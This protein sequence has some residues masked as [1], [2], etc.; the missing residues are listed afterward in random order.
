MMGTL[1]LR[2]DL[3]D[4]EKNKWLVK[5]PSLIFAGITHDAICV[6]TSTMAK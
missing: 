6:I 1:K 3:H 2:L 4:V 5:D